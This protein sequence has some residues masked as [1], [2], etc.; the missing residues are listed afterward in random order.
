MEIK[1][2][3]LRKDTVSQF[4]KLKIK[5]QSQRH[6]KTGGSRYM[7]EPNVK[8]SKGCIRDL[9]T[10]Y[11]LSKYKYGFDSLDELK[12]YDKK[13]ENY[14]SKYYNSLKYLFEKNGL[15]ILVLNR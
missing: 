1:F 8:E 11:W 5:E 10:I 13:W 4:V 12:L 6:H 3:I 9:N 14:L 15:K 7:L 2:K